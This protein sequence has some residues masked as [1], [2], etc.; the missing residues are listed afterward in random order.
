MDKL[1]PGVI[2]GAVLSIW[3]ARMV[4]GASLSRTNEDFLFAAIAL[5]LVYAIDCWVS[6]GS[7]PGYWVSMIALLVSFP[8]SSR[9]DIQW[10][11]LFPA[12]TFLVVG[13][14]DIHLKWRERLN[15]G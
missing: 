15:M 4:F 5:A 7:R 9:G 2:T 6:L 14:V 1:V 3:L 13:A 11:D 8:L 12:A 10:S